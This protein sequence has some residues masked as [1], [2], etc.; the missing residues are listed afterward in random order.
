MLLRHAI[1]ASG[2]GDFRGETARLRLGGESALAF[3]A[4]LASVP[5]VPIVTV[6]PSLTLSSVVPTWCPTLTAASAGIL[7]EL[8]S[9]AGTALVCDRE[10]LPS[11][12]KRVRRS[13][14]GS[15]RAS[16]ELRSFAASALATTVATSTGG[17]VASIGET[18]DDEDRS[19]PKSERCGDGV[20]PRRRRGEEVE[21]CGDAEALGEPPRDDDDDNPTVAAAPTAPALE[22]EGALK[23]PLQEAAAEDAV[24]KAADEAAL[25]ALERDPERLGEA[26]DR[27]GDRDAPRVFEELGPGLLP[28]LLALL[29][30]TVRVLLVLLTVLR[31]CDGVGD[32]A[33][34]PVRPKRPL[35]PE[36]G[37]MAVRDE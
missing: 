1:A 21:R 15:G 2:K 14:G 8:T 24:A 19:D 25:R 35:A 26:D 27:F 5:D 4:R 28:M 18:A 17:A 37:D 6:L 11:S 3:T 33:D 13:V 10:V 16:D 20:A 22:G 23:L 31:A 32:E 7:V 29:A 12:V 34:G 9:F 30:C 36:M